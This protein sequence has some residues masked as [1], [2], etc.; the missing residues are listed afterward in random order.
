MAKS[1][2]SRILNKRANTWVS[3]ADKEDLPASKRRKIVGTEAADVRHS[4]YSNGNF[5][6]EITENGLADTHSQGDAPQ[7]L[8]E[9]AVETSTSIIVPEEMML[10]IIK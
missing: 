1:F 9:T 4:N 5:L 10:Q 2:A 3:P 8:E 7:Q 6:E